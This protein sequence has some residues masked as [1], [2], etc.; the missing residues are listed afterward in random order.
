MTTMHLP[1][2][3][4]DTGTG[5][6]QPELLLL[7]KTTVDALYSPPRPTQRWREEFPLGTNHIGNSSVASTTSPLPP[8]SPPTPYTTDPLIV[9]TR[10][11]LLSV[12][13]TRKHTSTHIYI[14]TTR[15]DS[16]VA[17]RARARPR[18][19]RSQPLDRSD[20]HPLYI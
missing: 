17:W 20:N 5:I 12:P 9:Y 8:P 16:A 18:P 2:G 4:L 6:R 19:S 15:P 13:N 3:S 14:H 10:S 11:Q 7:E 1:T